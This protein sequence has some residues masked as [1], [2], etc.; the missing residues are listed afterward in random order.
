MYVKIGPYTNWIGPYQIAEQLKY[1]GVPETKR[2]KI[3]KYLSNT[4]LMDICNWIDERKKRKIKIK[5]HDYDTWGADHTLSLIIVPLLEKLKEN[6]HGAPFVK[7]EDLPEELRGECSSEEYSNGECDFEHL[8]KRWDYVLDEM[9]Y[10]FKEI[11]EDKLVKLD[12]FRVENG[13]IL[14]GKYFEAL[15]D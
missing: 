4:I 11:R 15:W 10:A 14:F 12:D 3:G 8:K 13:L 7:D 2:V 6:K 5:I 1:I 9:I